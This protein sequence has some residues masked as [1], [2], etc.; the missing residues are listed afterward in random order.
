MK[1]NI[2]IVYLLGV[3]VGLA[4]S[5]QPVSHFGKTTTKIQTHLEAVSGDDPSV[6]R[7]GVLGAGMASLMT[8]LLGDKAIAAT[9][10]P[11][12]ILIT[13]ANS[14]VGYFA[15]KRLAAQGHTVILAC[16]TLEK[17]NSAIE[18]VRAD[19]T[20]GTLVPAECNLAS[21]ESIRSFAKD[22]KAETLDVVCLNAAVSL[23]TE[24]KNVQRTADGFE[25]TGTI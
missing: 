11:Q 4:Q 7:R 12:T 19:V 10:E 23:N 3:L 14:G 8:L 20:T 18:K 21:L 16:R 17:A 5:F 6:G 2:N 22:L 9:S 1:L 13:G 15:T 24:D 25:L